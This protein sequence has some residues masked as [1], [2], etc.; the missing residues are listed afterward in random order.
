MVIEEASAQIL[1]EA[2]W[3]RVAWYAQLHAHMCHTHVCIYVYTHI[4]LRSNVVTQAFERLADLASHDM[5]NCMHTH[6]HTHI[7]KTQFCYPSVGKTVQG[8]SWSRVTWYAQ[9]KAH[10][11]TPTHLRRNFIARRWEDTAR[12][13]LISRRTICTIACTHTCIYINTHTHI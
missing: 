7:S 9:L 6:T 10:T 5:H 1:Q 12:G 2:R 8:A 13:S 11:H 3:F 4:Y